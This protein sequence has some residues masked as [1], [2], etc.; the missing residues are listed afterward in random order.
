MRTLGLVIAMM[1]VLSVSCFA[2]TATIDLYAT[3]SFISLPNIANDPSPKAVFGAAADYEL[4]KWSPET[5]S[6]IVYDPDKPGDFGNCMIGEGYIIRGTAGTVIS[7]NATP[8]SAMDMFIS[9]PGYGRGIG[10]RHLIGCPF[11]HPIKVSGTSSNIIFTNGCYQKTWAEAVAAGWVG[12]A[13]TF[14]TGAGYDEIRCDGSGE[15]TQLQPGKAYWIETH[16]DSLAMLIQ[17]N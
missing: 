4:M 5:Q 15:A 10:G 3:V 8:D 2:T 12:P 17:P 13:M 6:F 16:V 11:A 9:L 1:F 7:Y 14:F